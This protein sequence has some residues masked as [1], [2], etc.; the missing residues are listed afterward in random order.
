MK[1]FFF[2]LTFLS[3]IILGK[4]EYEDIL[5]A[6]SKPSAAS[7]RGHQVKILFF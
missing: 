4:N 6:Q 3:W 5:Q 1:Y 2:F 7:S